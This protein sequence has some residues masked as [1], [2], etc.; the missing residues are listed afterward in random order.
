MN[1]KKE[2]LLTFLNIDEHSLNYVLKDNKLY[3]NNTNIL[4]ECFLLNRLIKIEFGDIWIVY[5]NKS[6]IISYRSNINSIY[7]IDF[8]RYDVIDSD[9]H[10]FYNDS[11]YIIKAAG[12]YLFDKPDYGDIALING[13]VGSHMASYRSFKMLT[14][15]GIFISYRLT[16]IGYPKEGELDDENFDGQLTHSFECLEDLDGDCIFSADAYLDYEFN[17]TSKYTA[18]LASPY[19]K[20]KLNIYKNGMALLSSANETYTRHRGRIEFFIDDKG[21]LDFTANMK[22]THNLQS[23]DAWYHIDQIIKHKENFRSPFFLNFISSFQRIFEEHFKKHE[24]FLDVNIENVDDL[25]KHR[26]LIDMS[27]I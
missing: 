2:K 26:S 19:L 7:D 14:E 9:L 8:D 24:F 5:N 1:E 16:Y 13:K 12:S 22:I 20:E 23:W 27:K 4:D 15:E 18:Y 6:D 10:L 21:N 3:H 25:E 17:L 11:R